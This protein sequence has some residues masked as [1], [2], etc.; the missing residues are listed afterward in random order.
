MHM[1]EPLLGIAD[2]MKI[3]SL[4]K[5]SIY[6]KVAAARAGKIRFP[7]PAMDANQRLMWTVSSIESFFQE[8]SVLPQ[9]VI[10]D[11]AKQQRE[12]KSHQ[13]RQEASWKIL[14]KHGIS[15]PETK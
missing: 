9:I 10:P 14:E 8:K 6:R 1:F 3:F 11:P 12:K 4:S 15:R 13:N 2:I 7:L 5:V